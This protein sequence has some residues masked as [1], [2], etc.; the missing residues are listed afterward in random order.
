MS[1]NNNDGLASPKAKWRIVSV[2]VLIAGGSFPSAAPAQSQPPLSCNNF[3]LNNGLI[4]FE[5]DNGLEVSIYGNQT[6]AYNA[7]YKHVGG[8]D[9]TRGSASGGI[10]FG[11]SIAINAIWD[12]GPGAGLSNR[13]VGSI[14]N[15]GSAQGTTT[16]NLGTTNN[17]TTNYA[18]RFHCVG[19]PGI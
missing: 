7:D 2:A 6:Q 19:Q 14:N 16:N 17:W 1:T 4:W 12:Q 15:D 8:D 3:I 18:R 11:N 10:E 9:I 5:Q 13:Y